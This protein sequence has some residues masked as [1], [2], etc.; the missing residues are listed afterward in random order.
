MQSDQHVDVSAFA[1]ERMIRKVGEL[2]AHSLLRRANASGHG[3][4]ERSGLRE[5]GERINLA[6]TT[7]DIN[8]EQ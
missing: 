4:E 7:D 2:L 5:P 8:E 6:R 1:N 3:P